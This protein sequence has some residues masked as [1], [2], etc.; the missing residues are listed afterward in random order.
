MLR[1]IRIF[2][3]L[4]LVMVKPLLASDVEKAKIIIDT[5][6][7]HALEEGCSGFNVRIADKVWSY[8]HP[9]FRAAV[10]GLQ[11]GWLRYFSGTMGDAFNCATGLYDKD[12]TLMFQKQQMYEKGYMFTDVKGPHR[13]IDLYELLGEVGGKLVVTI[14]GFSETPQI[15]GELAR[16]CK[17]NNIEVEAWQFCNEPYFY[18][19]HRSVYWWND[20]YD[21][22][23]KMKPYADSIR[24]VF[25][26]AKLALNCTWDGIWGFMKEIH[27]YQE[28]NGA[29][30]NTFSK[31][32]YAPHVGG[33]EPFE[34][35]YQRANTKVIEATSPEAMQEIEDYSEEGI[36]MLITEFGVWNSPLNGIISAIYNVEYTLRQL[37]HPNTFLIA[38]HEISNKFKPAENRNQAIVD[39]YNSGNYIDTKTLLT[40]IK[41]DDEGK[42]LEILHQATNNSVYTWKTTIEGGALV[43]GLKGREETALY[44]RAFKGINGFDYL[45][46]TNRSGKE[47]Q[48]DVEIDGELLDVKAERAYMFSDLAQNRNIDQHY[49]EVKSTSL[50][51]PAYSIVMI[52]WKS[53]D[54]YAP[55]KTR[56]YKTKLTEQGVALSWWKRDLAKSYK[57]YAGT[58]PANLSLVKR[59]KGADKTHTVLDGLMLGQKYYFAVEAENKQ[60]SE[61][62]SDLTSLTLRQPAQPTIFKVAPRDTS[63][64]VMWRSVADALGYKVK[65]KAA[66]FEREYDAKNVFGYRISGLQYDQ[67]YTITVVAYNGLGESEPSAAV[68][69]IC[70]PQ[71]PLMPRNVS[72]KQNKDGHVYLHWTINDHKNKDVK[73]R[74]YRGT[75][76]HN[77]EPLVDGIVGNTYL[78]TTVV[79]DKVYYYTVKSYNLAGECNYYPNVATLIERDKVVNIEVQSIERTEDALLVTI[80]FDNIKAGGDIYYGLTY[81]DVSYLNVE[82]KEVRTDKA[83]NGQ[84]VISIPNSDLIKGRTYA[85]KG[86]VN[87]NG[88]PISSMP[89]YTQVK[90]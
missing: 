1:K 13:I 58:N 56:I 55:T 45:V 52:K 39:A 90:F 31:H 51:V 68:E 3:F 72:A 43:P 44:A 67:P 6:N 47:H 29:Y 66:G 14:N 34:K 46:I 9:D 81:S 85:I 33:K 71:L 61:G 73:Y 17:N 78:D 16:F 59:L 87:T 65:V 2:S 4:F 50:Q 20:G 84:F 11:P 15:A 5:K 54:K 21:Y 42:A 23:A 38:S 64:T 36:P 25:P 41:K 7:G 70:D 24:A 10:H 22:A 82:E 49:D 35:A 80:K 27:R 19:P 18:V 62:L 88:S 86:F 37:E 75:E 77:F 8:E 63:I 57:V 79:K 48:F 26:E 83:E 53:P 30:W 40:G 32:S 28:E 60:G 76:P 74:L 89:P 69:A 12:Y